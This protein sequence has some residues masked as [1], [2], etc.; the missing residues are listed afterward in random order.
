MADHRFTELA[1]REHGIE[2]CQ[3]FRDEVDWII[4]GKDGTY[5]FAIMQTDMKHICP[6]ISR[7]FC[8]R[9]SADAKMNG[10]SGFVRIL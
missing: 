4:G 5:W 8:S 2:F 7:F 10:K 6:D 9:D 3:A 1:E